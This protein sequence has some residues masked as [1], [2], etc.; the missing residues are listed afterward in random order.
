[1]EKTNESA[2]E[3]KQASDRQKALV[4]DMG[5]LLRRCEAVKQRASD[6]VDESIERYRRAQSE[7]QMGAPSTSRTN[8]SGDAKSRASAEKAS[9]AAAVPKAA[10]G[11]ASIQLPRPLDYETI[12]LVD[13]TPSG[14]RISYT[15]C[16]ESSCLRFMQ[17]MLCDGTSLDDGSQ[18]TR[19]DL[20]LVKRRVPDEQVRAFFRAYPEILPEAE[21][22][23]QRRGFK[24]REDWAQ[25]VAHKPFFTYKR[26]ACGVYK[27]EYFS[28]KKTAGPQEPFLWELEMEPCVHN[29]ISLCR[30]FLGVD[31]T[32]EDA[33][34]PMWKRP[35]DTNHEAFH[36]DVSGDAQPHLD[37]AM[38]QLSRR[39]CMQLQARLSTTSAFGFGPYYTDVVFEFNGRRAWKWSLWRTAFQA[40][41]AVFKELGGYTYSD[42]EDAQACCMR[43]SS[44]SVIEEI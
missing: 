26:S 22:A 40:P 38:R 31:F 11:T 17:A 37:A 21:Y 20:D 14:R 25:L 36:H 27:N 4:A 35:C 8:S 28:G 7:R 9:A 30:H 5:K 13:T 2:R 33:L 19:V 41:E 39:G 10:T 42:Q 44:H 6:A 29:V 15:D 18:P 12:K 16:M 23:P 24:A 34:K 3:A 43:T 1:M 32:K